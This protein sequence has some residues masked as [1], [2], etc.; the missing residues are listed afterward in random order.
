MASTSAPDFPKPLAL[1]LSQ[2][3]LA[4]INAYLSP[5]TPEEI[6]KWGIEYLPNLY[7]TTAFGLTGLVAIDMLSK[8]NDIAAA[9]HLS[10]HTVSLPGNL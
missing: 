1:T 2:S 9:A 6:L 4:K 3:D 7:Q 8:N 5:L 10:G